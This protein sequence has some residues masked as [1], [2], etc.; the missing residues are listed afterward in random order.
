MKPFIFSACAAAL[1]AGASGFAGYHFGVRAEQ[2]ATLENSLSVNQQFIQAAKA[3]SVHEMDRLLKLGADVNA[4]QIPGGFTALDRAAE[5]GYANAVEWLLAHG[6]DPKR[7]FL[8]GTAAI[9]AAQARIAQS[10]QVVETLKA[11][12]Q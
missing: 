10:T 5:R 7:G 11:R 9:E 1:I 2:R 4:A 8:H 12:V 3:G 6:A